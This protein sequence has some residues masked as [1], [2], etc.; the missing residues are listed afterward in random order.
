MAYDSTP[1][2]PRRWP[3]GLPPLT[4]EQVEAFGREMDALREAVI[5]SRGQRDAAYIRRVIRL[6]R[7]L[8]LTSRGV[9]YGGILFPPAFVIGAVGLGVAKILEN[10]EIGHNVMHGQWDWMRDPAIHSSTW[11]WDTVCPSSQWKNTHNVEHH[12]WTNVIGKD[13]DI[14]YGILRMSEAEKWH[15][16]HLLNPINNALLAIFFQWGV[17]LHDAEMDQIART[18]SLRAESRGKLRELWRKARKQVLKDYLLFPALAGPFFLPVLLA[19][20]GANLIRNLW[21]YMIIFCGHFPD[22]VHQFTEA[23]IENESR[24]GW[25]LRQ[26]LGSANIEGGPLMHLLSGNLSFQIEHHLFP[27]LP[28]NRYAELSPKVKAVCERYG[29]PYNSASLRRQ[30]GTTLGRVFRL[31]LPTRSGAAVTA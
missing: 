10:M 26:L 30:F 22:G 24:G 17:G 21:S 12:T 11:E 3:I 20:I 7:G 18:G 2:T 8:E 31:A 27:D 14:G 23:E 1:S 13:R 19:N 6:Q 29:L 4:P 25:Y 28:S 9:I 15:P 16:V 5:A